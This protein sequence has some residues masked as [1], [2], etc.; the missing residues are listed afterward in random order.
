MWDKIGVTLAVVLPFAG[1]ILTIAIK[2]INNKERK[3]LPGC[4]EEFV[5]TKTE[6]EAMKKG[7]TYRTSL[8]IAI[9]AAMD[10]L[11]DK[12]S[13][14]EENYKELNKSINKTAI[15]VAVIKVNVKNISKVVEEIRANGKK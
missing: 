9:Q 8:V 4:N 13:D 2:I 7:S 1:V 10:L 6:M 5:K 15:A 11:K 3:V 14:A 12:T